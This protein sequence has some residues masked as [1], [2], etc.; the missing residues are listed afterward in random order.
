[1]R[2]ALA[3]CCHFWVNQTEIFVVLEISSRTDGEL[4]EGTST[5]V[6][7]VE[8]ENLNVFVYDEVSGNETCEAMKFRKI[9]SIFVSTK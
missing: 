6:L 9:Y 5:A 7:D 8:S 4:A 1:M 2:N 3:I